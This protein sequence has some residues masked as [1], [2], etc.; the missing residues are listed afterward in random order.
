MGPTRRSTPLSPARGLA[1]LPHRE[2]CIRQARAWRPMPFRVL[3]KRP[4]FCHRRSHRH[5][6]SA[7]GPPCSLWVETRCLHGIPW[8]RAETAVLW[9]LPSRTEASKGL[10]LP[11]GSSIA[12]QHI[13]LSRNVA[14]AFL[15][16]SG[17]LWAEARCIPSLEKPVD[18]RPGISGTGRALKFRVLRPEVQSLPCS[19]DRLKVRLKPILGKV[20]KA[21]LSTFGRIACG[22]GWIS[23]QPVAISGRP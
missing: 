6:A 15:E 17:L 10:T 12:D 23:P 22:R 4:A 1:C 11:H 7:C 9:C 5:P 14:R 3:P 20:R 13:G 19:E 18:R 8:G 21:D 16:R 2:R